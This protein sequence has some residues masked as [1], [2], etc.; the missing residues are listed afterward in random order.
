MPPHYQFP[1]KV[2]LPVLWSWLRLHPRSLRAD[3]LACIASLYYAP[4]VEGRENIPPHGPCIVVFNHYSRPGIPVWWLALSIAATLPMEAHTIMTNEWTAPGKWYEPLKSAASKLLFNRLAR[5]YGFT[6]MPPMPPREKDVAGRAKA[7]RSVLAHVDE[8]PD[9][10]LLLAPEGGDSPD[11]KLMAPPS[12]AGRFLLL[13]AGKGLSFV[14]AGGWDE[15]GE[16]C[17]RFGPGFSLNIPKILSNDEKDRVASKVVMTAIAAL[18]PVG[19]RGNF[20][21]Q[22]RAL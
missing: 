17:I 8:N 6:P 12:G 4:R 21:A 22:S 7:V 20:G 5:M 18:L 13:L 16:L 3:A 9:A 19:L 2:L 10:A 11:G 14:P 15:A 1:L